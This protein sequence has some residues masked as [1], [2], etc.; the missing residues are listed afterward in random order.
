MTLVCAANPG[1]T[2]AECFLS[3]LSCSPFNAVQTVPA[4]CFVDGSTQVCSTSV[5]VNGAQPAE[6]ASPEVSCQTF[7]TQPTVASNCLIDN[8]TLVCLAA[9]AGTCSGTGVS[10]VPYNGQPIGSNCAAEGGTLVCSINPANALRPNPANTLV[11]TANFALGGG[12]ANTF[13]A[14]GNI[15]GFDET[16]PLVTIQVGQYT[17]TIPITSFLVNGNQYLYTTNPAQVGISQLLLDFGTQTFSVTLGKLTT[18]TLTSPAPVQI[19][20]GKY[21]ACEMIMFSQ[22][23]ANWTFSNTMNASFPCLITAPPTSTLPGV[24]AGISANLQF[25]LPAAQIPIDGA[26]LVQVDTSFNVIATICHLTQILPNCS[27]ML[28]Q[29][30]PGYITISA[31]PTNSGLK[32]NFSPG[33][34]LKVINNVHTAANIALM[35]SASTSATQIYQ[36]QVALGGNSKA[37]TQMTAA[38]VQNL[39]GVASVTIEPDGF[40]IGVVFNF[41]GTLHLDAAPEGTGGANYVGNRTVVGTQAFGFSGAGTTCP[42]PDL[43]Y[44]PAYFTGTYLQNSSRAYNWYPPIFPSNPQFSPGT[45]FLANAPS[46][47]SFLTVNGAPG[48]TSLKI[49]D[50]ESFA[51]GLTTYGTIYILTHGSTYHQKDGSDPVGFLTNEPF[52][53]KLPNSVLSLSDYRNLTLL[54]PDAPQ[55]TLSQR[56]RTNTGQPYLV[57]LPAFIANL[58]TNFPHSIVLAGAC[59]SG[60]NSSMADAFL[61]KGAGAYIGYN[62]TVSARFLTESAMAILDRL[63]KYHDTA[64]GAVQNF[65]GPNSVYSQASGDPYKTGCCSSTG[66]EDE[67]NGVPTVFPEGSDLRY[68]PEFTIL[69]AGGNSS[70]PYPVYPTTKSSPSWAPGA[71][72]QFDYN[73]NTQKMSAIYNVSQTDPTKMTVYGA[74]CG[75]KDDVVTLSTSDPWITIDTSTIAAKDVT[76]VTDIPID[77]LTPITITGLMGTKPPSDLSTGYVGYIRAAVDPSNESKGVRDPS[78]PTGAVATNEVDVGLT[79][80]SILDQ[81]LSAVSSVDLKS[82][83]I[84]SNT[85]SASQTLTITNLG[86]TFLNVQTDDMI[87][88]TGTTSPCPSSGCPGPFTNASSFGLNPSFPNYNSTSATVTLQVDQAYGYYYYSGFGAADYQSLLLIQSNYPF[89]YPYAQRYGKVNLFDQGGGSVSV[90]PITWTLNEPDCYNVAGNY[91]GSYTGIIPTAN[92]SHPTTITN[93]TSLSFASVVY[94]SPPSSPGSYPVQANTNSWSSNFEMDVGYL[95]FTPG[96]QGSGYIN[97]TGASRTPGSITGYSLSPVINQYNGRNGTGFLD[98]SVGY[99]D[100]GQQLQSNQYLWTP[101]GANININIYEP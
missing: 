84:G 3:G 20:A 2:P 30:G 18:T 39:P 59:D 65:S 62:A 33:L 76:D 101:S 61:L 90:T 66:C 37:A 86:T 8:G 85:P 68:A 69:T 92:G 32:P 89:R 6:C 48:I 35:N 72:L 81:S 1:G 11:T 97:F 83:K 46:C 55:L 77:Q 41:G 49:S 24:I 71:P 16:A 99:E 26:D 64:S 12:T 21:N 28:Q 15:S 98:I 52:N 93:T 100:N 58:P 75:H 70:Q 56:I 53:Q 80:Y 14:Q 4:N 17:Q 13:T 82:V 63:I 78:N 91:L 51:Y 36:N 43:L 5:A 79:Y 44:T 88:M 19:S 31:V 96:Y 22:N 7:N 94:C 40:S 42:L 67:S 87:G 27:A 10:C 95:L 29:N 38:A 23:Q 50:I 9:L 34:V 60:I 54:D 45:G 57:V 74:A 25:S 73:A 47:P